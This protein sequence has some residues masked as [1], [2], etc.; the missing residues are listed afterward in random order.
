MSGEREFNALVTAIERAVRAPKGTDAEVIALLAIS[1]ARQRYEAAL[2]AS[3]PSSGGAP[4][5]NSSTYG[6]L[7]DAVRPMIAAHEWDNKTVSEQRDWCLARLGA[8]ADAPRE[9]EREAFSRLLAGESIIVD[10][11]LMA[12][13]GADAG[14][15][16][17]EDVLAILDANGWEVAMWTRREINDEY[18]FGWE[19]FERDIAGKRTVH[20]SGDTARQAF[21]AALRAAQRPATDTGGP[22]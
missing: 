22:S 1:G 16:E 19:V 12:L 3:A 8:A 13:R 6:N 20:G 11:K 4:G 5:E 7:P 2:S 9:G 14:G 10:G 18:I 15:R 21:D 17:G